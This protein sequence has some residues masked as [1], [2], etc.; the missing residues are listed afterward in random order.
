MRKGGLG[1]WLRATAVALASLT[2]AACGGGGGSDSGGSSPSIDSLTMSPTSISLVKGETYNFSVTANYSDG[3]TGS[4][5]T[6]ASWTV[7]DTSVATTSSDSP[8]QLTAT[9]VGSVTLTASYNGKEATSSVT[10][11]AATYESLSVSPGSPTLP[12]GK[13]LQFF[14]K[15]TYPSGSTVDVSDQAAWSV[16]DTSIATIDASTGLVTAVAEGQVTVSATFS[17]LSSSATLTVSEPAVISVSV[18]P[19]SATSVQGQSQAFTATAVYSDG[20][21]ADVSSSATWKSS[22]TSVATVDSSGVGTGVGVGSVTVTASFGQYGG[23]SSWTVTAYQ[24]SWDPYYVAISQSALADGASAGL[25]VVRSDDPSAGATRVS[26]DAVKV[27]AHLQAPIDDGAGNV[28]GYEPY[29]LIYATE[30]ASGGDHLYSLTLDAANSPVP[31]QLSSAVFSDADPMCEV[32]D[33]GPQTDPSATIMLFSR[34]GDDGSCDTSDDTVW[35]VSYG[36][37]AA[38]DPVAVDFP[39]AA[40]AR[41]HH[42]IIPAVDGSVAAVLAV[43]DAGQLLRYAGTDFSDS[44]VMAS[45]VASINPGMVDDGDVL[46]ILNSTS[47]V[48]QL[49][50][51]TATGILSSSLYQLNNT[52]TIRGALVDG[53]F[54]LPDV[55]ATSSSQRVLLLV[56]LAPDG[57]SSAK[58]TNSITVD[59]SDTYSDPA[60]V[61]VIDTSLILQF[62]ATSDTGTSLVYGAVVDGSDAG[63]NEIET[64]EG[65][66]F[67]HVFVGSDSVFVSPESGG[68]NVYTADGDKEQTISDKILVGATYELDGAEIGSSALDQMVTTDVYL[69]DYPAGEGAG[70]ERMDVDSL[71]ATALLDGSTGV[72]WAAPSGHGLIN[73][74]LGGGE[75]L[76]G[77]T[78]NVQATVDGATLDSTDAFVLDAA[79]DT[80]YQMTDTASSSEMTY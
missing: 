5:T 15:A 30:G 37:D 52:G 31:V 20:S 72:A 46:F 43:N 78:D 64:L 63:M 19:P 55:A 24:A 4:V 50:H 9:G 66:R 6:S 8:G 79:N 75:P 58:V 80:L 27:I 45:S 60:V 59:S 73:G 18:D 25:L 13:T 67:A 23:A 1:S 3:T 16:S 26:S 36:D 57:S 33:L 74:I 51:I 34:A 14:A 47:S 17:G 69:Q 29:A 22:D 40:L 7:S 53:Y 48:S 56:R 10:V 70:V 28:H 41:D 21:T 65:G 49:R 39:A 71:T 44:D 61:G 62:N 77:Y 35:R 12:Q 32:T 2:A 54:Y 38:T 76:L 68:V 42:L 11:T